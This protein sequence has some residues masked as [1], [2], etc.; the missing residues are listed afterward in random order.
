VC[1]FVA[2]KRR[3]YFFKGFR[4]FF[5]QLSEKKY[6]KP[7]DEHEWNFLWAIINGLHPLGAAFGALASSHL[8]NRLGR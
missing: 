1:A 3:I 7:L 2:S 5:N 8:S 6:S 4:E